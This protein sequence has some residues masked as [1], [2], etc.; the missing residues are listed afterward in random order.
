MNLPAAA[1]AFALS[2]R[3]MDR[4]ADLELNLDFAGSTCQMPAS[5]EAA[6]ICGSDTVKINAA[7]VEATMLRDVNG[8]VNLDNMTLSPVGLQSAPY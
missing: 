5:V 7:R 1:V 6:A 3:L 2:V 8:L 4:V